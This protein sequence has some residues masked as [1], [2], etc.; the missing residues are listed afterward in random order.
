[1]PTQLFHQAILLRAVI[2]LDP[3]LCLRGTRRDDLDP[4]CRAHA[5]ELRQRR[6]PRHPLFL[7]GHPDIDIFPVGV[8]RAGNSVLLDPAPQHRDRR[9]DPFLSSEAP[10]RSARGIIDQRQQTARRPA[11]FE[12]RMDA[13]IELDQF[14]EV[15]HALAPP[16]IRTAFPRTTPQPRRQHPPPQRLMVD[17]E[18]ILARQVLGRERRPKALVDRAAVLLANQ[19]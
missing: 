8:E 13:A 11:A 10:E 4:Q 17:G 6:R 19:R 5:T 16:P 15:R 12:P 18:P 2:A 9:P 1:V 14:P 7:I 3:A